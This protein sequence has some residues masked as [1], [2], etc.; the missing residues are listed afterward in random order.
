MTGSDGTTTTGSGAYTLTEVG[1]TTGG[2]AYGE[3]VTG[4]ESVTATGTGNDDVGTSQTTTSATGTYVR[5][6]TGATSGRA[7]SGSYGYT[8]TE[9]ADALAGYFTR[10]E[11]GT[12]RYGLVYAFDDVSG[13]AS[14]D[15]G[16]LHFDTTGVPFVDPDPEPSNAWYDW[17]NP[18][19]VMKAIARVEGNVAG[20][21]ADK[22][23]A[24]GLDGAAT[25][26]DVGKNI[27]VTVESLSDGLI[28]IPFVLAQAPA[29][30]TL[31]SPKHRVSG[32][33]EACDRTEA[34]SRVNRRP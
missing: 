20:A 3:T 32:R 17:V 26:A 24:N 22:L 15:T 30:A 6:D 7:G 28:A 19:V 12:D 13:E 27:A 10:S 16:H 1:Q 21:A 11:T 9:T 5:T 2:V 25:A 23:R 34:V 4:S 18:F 29:P 33:R 31:C 14:G 8:N